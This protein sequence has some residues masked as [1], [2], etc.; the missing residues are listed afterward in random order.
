MDKAT[1]KEYIKEYDKIHRVRFSISLNKDKEAD[2]IESIITEGK[3]NKQKG[4]KSLL[5]KGIRYNMQDIN[6]PEIC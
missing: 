3:G 5:Y 4:I 2:L 6:N 1:F